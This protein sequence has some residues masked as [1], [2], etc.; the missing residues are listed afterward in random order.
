MNV[1]SYGKTKVA[2]YLGY[3]TQ[4]ISVNFLPLLY[5]TFQ[6]DYSV[7]LAQLGLLATV[8]FVVQIVVDLLAARFNKHL[9]YRVG[10]VA[11]HVFASAGLVSLSLLPSL[12][13]DPY[14]GI[15]ISSLLLSVGGGLIEVLIS[16]VIDAIP[17]E[18]KAGEMSLLH[19]F[20]CWG[21]VGV[22]LFS[23]AFFVAFGTAAWRWLTLLWALIPALTA[24]LFA[25]VPLPAKP[26]EAVKRKESTAFMRSGLFW[27]FMALMLCSGATELGLAQWAS[28]FAER[29]LR[30]SKTLG[31]LLGPCAFA[32]F[33]GASRVV[34]AHLSVRLDARRLL[35]SCAF[36]CVFSY[37]L[38]VLSPWP[39]V[40]L[41]G[42]CL[43]GWFV[44][45]MWPGILSLA[46]TH[47]PV[48]G[49]S[50]FALLALCG[51]MGCSLAPTMVGAVSDRLQVGLPLADA[52]RGGFGVCALFPVMLVIGLLLLR[53]RKN[54]NERTV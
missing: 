34:Y 50:M 11:A 38:I 32:L 26:E 22:A 47:Y 12:L 33:Q 24:V 19:S 52:L 3:I 37:G 10:C 9:S 23:T 36:G 21:V 18:G 16:P 31:D 20:Y 46:S 54:V 15:L 8:V 13:A 5:V 53:K 40:S 14:V 4:A 25:V 35:V 7:T 30:I 27:L 42:F 49:T 51:D 29:G 17:G 48:G 43:S 44:G 28:L 2:C 6:K 45:P 39:F 1:V 41:L